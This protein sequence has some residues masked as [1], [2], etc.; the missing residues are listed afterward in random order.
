MAKMKDIVVALYRGS[1]HTI[2][3][4]KGVLADGTIAGGEVWKINRKTNK[5]DCLFTGIVFSYA[6]QAFSDAVLEEIDME[7]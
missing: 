5:K 2:K 3:L 7:I 1:I 4:H 6:R